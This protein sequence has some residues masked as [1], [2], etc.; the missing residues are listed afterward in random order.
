MPVY[1]DSLFCGSLEIE[2]ESSQVRREGPAQDDLHP[3]S[4]LIDIE[5][6][7]EIIVCTGA[8]TSYPVVR[9]GL[10]G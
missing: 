5:W 3:Q 4:Q 6:L 9:L 1:V 10:C 7:A 8:K 2:Y